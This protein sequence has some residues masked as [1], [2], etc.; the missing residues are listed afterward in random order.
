MSTTDWDDL[1][2]N[3]AIRYYEG[4][5]PDG[6]VAEMKSEFGFDPTVG[7]EEHGVDANGRPWGHRWSWDNRSF[8]IPAGLVEAVY[9][10]YRWP[11]GS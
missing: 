2:P 7:G 6:F 11:I 5:D 8:A 1:C 4:D 3:G 9:G 10:S